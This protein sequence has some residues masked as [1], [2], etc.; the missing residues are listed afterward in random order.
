MRTKNKFLIASLLLSSSILSSMP[1]FAEKIKDIDVSGN[2]RIEK[3]TII[4]YISL[5]INQEFEQK[6]LLESV[7]ELYKTDLFNDVSLKFNN[8]VLR[9]YVKETPLVTKVQF[10]GNS[11]IKTSVLSKEIHSHQGSSLRNSDVKLDVE[12]IREIY[13][14]SG[15][16]AVNVSSKIENIGN[17]RVKLIFEISEGPKTGIR[18]I[19]FVGNKNYKDS[20]LR[21]VIITKQSAWFRF[22]DSSDTYDPDRVEYDK[23]LMRRFYNSIGYADF[24]IIS[25][26]AELSP[27]RENFTLTYTIEEGDQYTYGDVGIESN[28]KEINPEQFL[29]LIT[30][31]KGKIYNACELEAIS[32][33]IND[34]LADMGYTGAVIYPEEK[35]DKNNK[36]ISIKYIIEKASKTYLD[37]I[38]INGNLKTR[39]SV[40]RRQF[41]IS[42][43]DL[44]NR[45]AINDG[46]KN[47]RNLD[48]FET[49]AV[50]VE[51]SPSGN[52][53][54][55]VNINVEEKS[56][57]S[58]QFE[59]GY[60][61]MEGPVGRI[62]FIERNLIGTGR[63]LTAG[64]DKYRKK[65]ATHAGITDPYFMDKELLA[66]FSVFNVNAQS[67]SGDMP[68][69]IKSLGGNIRFG[70]EVATDLRHDLFYTLKKDQIGGGTRNSTSIFIREQY[71]TMHTSSIANSLT[72]DQL[73][74]AVV[75]KNGYIVSFT[76]TDAGLGGDNKYMKHEADFKVFKSF[77]NNAYT[78]KVAVDVGQIHG[79][80][81]K[82]V[83]ISD[84]TNLGD[85]TFRGFAAA[86]LGPRVKETKEA[87]G[88]QKYY[89]V[90]TELLFPIGLPKEFNVSGALFTDI[91]SL[92]D[93]DVINPNNYSRSDVNDSSAPRVSVGMGILWIT[94]FAP[95]R[96]DYAIPIK[97]QKYDETERWS[98]RFSTSF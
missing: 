48:Y 83:R 96:L 57:S 37:K 21:S 47:I 13:R 69:S 7:K 28:I 81:G 80:G 88:G 53:K 5:K 14:K 8:G 77:F 33:L 1:A 71:G 43:G 94:R 15:R 51:Q 72:Y 89:T 41:K 35:K 98:F 84:R 3:E 29:G 50:D 54:A 59:V 70:Y 65:I 26:I 31:K 11:R 92:W 75:P 97:K 61:S 23:Y 49:V 90:S 76:E 34:R 46:E 73:D 60:N 39:D 10:S 64:V 74:S 42:E 85:Y 6:Q 19:N 58:I 27:T 66:G 22:M 30:L 79:F 82:K 52:N 95:I 86:G 87:L 38:N 16:Y 4:N 20:E 93:F 17:N 36:V 12:K 91:G 68:Y 2:E 62:N 78:V 25:A 18:Y 24:R 63:Y 55:D 32:E 44:F 40:I 67:G 45:T 56:T 9:V